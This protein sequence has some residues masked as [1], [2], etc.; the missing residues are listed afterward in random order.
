MCS[1]ELS[2]TFFLI[3]T[4][5]LKIL[6][7]WDAYLDEKRVPSGQ[8][9]WRQPKITK[10]SET[11]ESGYCLISVLLTA[12]FILPVVVKVTQEYES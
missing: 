7:A 8:H 12:D 6:V 1:G 11:L 5:S 4:I 2:L 3:C 9:P 10:L